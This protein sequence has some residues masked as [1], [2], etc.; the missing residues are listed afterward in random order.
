[1]FDLVPEKIKNPI[2]EPHP[3]ENKL[4]IEEVTDLVL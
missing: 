2:S 1:M 4:K 3:N